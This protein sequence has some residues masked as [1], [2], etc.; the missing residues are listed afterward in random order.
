MVESV[1]EDGRAGSYWKLAG[2]GKVR[3]FCSE[4]SREPWEGAEQ[5]RLM[6]RLNYG[7]KTWQRDL[8]G[9]RGNGW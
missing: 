7:I 6:I 8:K 3:G 2:Y 1:G 4:G 5:G 9:K